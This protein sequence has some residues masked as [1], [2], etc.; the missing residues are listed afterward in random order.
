M[1]LYSN[2]S[3]S[4]SVHLYTEKFNSYIALPAADAN[5]QYNINCAKLCTLIETNDKSSTWLVSICT[6]GLSPLILHFE[7][8]MPCSYWNSRQAESDT[9]LPGKYSQNE[10]CKQ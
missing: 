2:S 10:Q 7:N 5:L 3:S 4:L 8:Y 6:L 1:I 9:Q